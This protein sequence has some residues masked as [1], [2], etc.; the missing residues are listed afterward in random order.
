MHVGLH[1]DIP[2]FEQCGVIHVSNWVKYLWL[3][4]HFDSF[5]SRKITIDIGPESAYPFHFD[6]WNICGSESVLAVTG[7]YLP[8]SE[9]W[10]TLPLLPCNLTSNRRIT[11]ITF[12]KMSWVKYALSNRYFVVVFPLPSDHQLLA[13]VSA[14]TALS[15]ELQSR[16][17]R[18]E[19]VTVLHA[20]PRTLIT[21]A[22]KAFAFKSRLRRA[23]IP[24]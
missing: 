20:G 24:C 7:I 4:M 21:K 5:C 1:A 19:Q 22:A 8:I 16:R 15:L 11:Q 12:N 2:I 13:R 18:Y 3:W 10:L 9:P 14:V 17:R 6:Y 23:A